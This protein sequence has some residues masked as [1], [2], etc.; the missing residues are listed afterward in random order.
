VVFHRQLRSSTRVAGNTFVCVMLA[1]LLVLPIALPTMPWGNVV[2]HRAHPVELLAPASQTGVIAIN[3]HVERLQHAK[4][5]S[6]SGSPFLPILAEA[7]PYDRWR[8]LAAGEQLRSP[9]W[10]A[11]YPHGSRSPP[12]VIS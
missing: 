12:A 7:S 8:A 10:W 4:Q 5:Q 1:V 3:R 9:V 2:D 6:N 11:T